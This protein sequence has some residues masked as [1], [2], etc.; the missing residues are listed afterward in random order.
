M[1]KKEKLSLDEFDLDLGMIEPDSILSDIDAQ[2]N[3]DARDK[4]SRNPVLDVFKG[5][6]SGIKDTV[7]TPSFINQ[8]IKQSLPKTYGEITSGVGEIATGISSLYD[9]A[10]KELKP[11]VSRIAKKVDRLVPEENKRLK[12]V[13]SKISGFFGDESTGINNADNQKE[14]AIANS[15][16]AVFQT[17][18]E[19]DQQSEARDNVR[20]QIRE[21]VDKKRFDSNFGLLTSINESVVRLS[22]Y[23]DRINQAFQKKTL[24]LQY[25]QFYAQSELLDTSKRFFEIFKNQNDSVVKNTAL[26]EFVKITNSEKF[27]EIAKNK[28]L[29]GVQSSIFGSES[30][31]GRAMGQMKKDAKEYVSGLKSQLEMSM[32]ALD[33]IEMLREQ[34]EQMAGLGIEMDSPAKMAGGAAGAE[35]AKYTRNKFTDIVKPIIEEDPTI[36]EAL[37]KGANFMSNMSGGVKD[38]QNSDSFKKKMESDG[39][40]GKLARG[41]NGLMSYF[42]DKKF[43][44]ETSSLGNIQSMDTPTNFNNKTQR[45]IVEVIP[46]YLA[47][48]FRE[49]TVLRT[50]DDKTL[51]SYFDYNK[52][53]FIDKNKMAKRI[54]STLS[55]K[56]KASGHDSSLDRVINELHKDDA[57]VSDFDKGNLKNFYSR[58]A[59]IPNLAYSPENIQNTDAYKELD[60]RTR[61]RVD[62]GLSQKI[63][64]STTPEAGQHQF[65]KR[66]GDVKKSLPD[67]RAEIE[68]LVK[69]GYGEFLVEKGLVTE[70]ED[71]SYT[72]DE[73]KYF[74]F[75]RKESI[76]T[77]DKNA[78]KNI[79]SS[80]PKDILNSISGHV[81]SDINSKQSISRF[82]PKGALGA[83]KKTRIYNWLYK[84]GEGDDQPHTGPMAQDV[85][86]TM[87]ENAAP[88]GTSLD[89]TTMN[90]VNMAA[91][92]AL[93]EKVT[94][95]ISGQETTKILGAIKKDTSLIA[96]SF[97]KGRGRSGNNRGSGSNFSGGDGYS[98]IAGNLVKSIT[99]LVGRVGSD[100]FE[101]GSKAISF[102]K[103]K[104]AKPVMDFISK[105][106]TNNKDGLKDTFKTLFTKAG[107]LAGSV[108]DFGQDVITNKLPAGFK[109][110]SDLAS[111]AKERLLRFV[112]YTK[113]VYIQGKDSPALRANLLK[114]GHY[115]DQKSGE[116]I[117]SFKD[118]KG[119][120][121]NKLGEVIL[122]EEDFA[123][124]LVDQE[125]KKID[126]P[127]MKLIK[128]VIGIGIKGLRRTKNLIGSIFKGS[129]EK[130]DQFTDWI[131]QSFGK[132]GKMD[133]GLGSER[134]YTVLT[135]IR[136]TLQG[137]NQKGPRPRNGRKNTRP[138]QAKAEANT[139][140]QYGNGKNIIDTLKDK[141]SELLNSDKVNEYKDKGLGLFNKVQETFS[142]ENRDGLIDKF[143]Q[144]SLKEKGDGLIDT[145]KSRFS[146][147]GREGLLTKVGDKLSSIKNYD[148]K[149]KTDVLK[150][151]LSDK[152]KEKKAIADEKIAQYREKFDEKKALAADKPTEYR[153]KIGEKKD[154]LKSKLPSIK[155]VKKKFSKREEENEG[156]LNWRGKAIYNDRDGSGKRDGSWEDRMKKQEADKKAKKKDAAKADLDPRYKS[157]ENIIDTIFKQAGS[158]FSLLSGGV[159]GMLGQAGSLFSAVGGMLGIGGKGGVIGGLAKGLGGLIKAPFKMIGGAIGAAKAIGTPIASAI[160]ATKGLPMMGKLASLAGTVRNVALTGSILTGGALGSVMG[161]VGA[162]ISALGAVLSS[163][164]V[165]G[166][167]ALAA[168]GYGAYKAYKRI[169]RDS[170]DTFSDIRIKQYGLGA[171]ENQ[172]RYNH[173]ALQL[174]AYLMD[175]R[176]AYNN[177]RPFIIEK[178]IDKQELLSIFDIDKEDDEQIGKFNTWFQR[179]FKPFFLTHLTAL[180]S[181]N[182]KAKLD[183]IVNFKVEQKLKFLSLISFESG[184]YEESASPFK[185]L[186]YLNVDKS[187]PLNSIK[188]AIDKLNEQLS[189]DKDKSSK[190]T[191]DK[192][193]AGPAPE[194]PK[195][196]KPVKPPAPFK[197]NAALIAGNTGED[198]SKPPGQQTPAESGAISKANV[199]LADGPLKDGKAGMQYIKL[200]N[201][202]KLDNLNPELLKNFFAM[203]Q[204]YG[205][206]TAKSILVKSGGRSRAQ[207]EALYRKDPKKAAPPGRSLH[208][209]GLALDADEIAMNE[210]DKLGLMRKYGFTRPVGGEPW[211]VEPAG[212]QSDLNGAK[213]DANNAT[214]KIA[215]SLF[216]GGGGVGSIPGSPLGKRNTSMALQLLDDSA[217]KK[218]TIAANDEKASSGPKTLADKTSLPEAK[219]VAQPNQKA[220]NEAPAASGNIAN[221]G[222]VTQQYA[223]Q[224]VVSDSMIPKEGEPKPES[225]STQETA[226]NGDVKGIIKQVAQKTDTDPNL[227]L[228]FAAMESSLN[229]N[230][231]AG[232]GGTAKGLYGFTNRTWNEKVSQFGGKYGISKDTS[233][234]DPKA[235]SYMVAEYIKQNKNALQSVKSNISPADIYL[236]HFLGTSGAKKFLT[237][238]QNAPG[239]SV[240]PDAAAA[241]K[242]YFYDNGQPL[243]VSQVYNK[244]ASKINKV[245]KQFGINL[246]E[247]S[248]SA[249]KT[250]QPAAKIDNVVPI[251]KAK[252]P[253]PQGSIPSDVQ[254]QTSPENQPTT[255]KPR[256]SIFSA[257]Y[258]SVLNTSGK[259]LNNKGTE[260]NQEAMSRVN[261]TLDKSLD[262]QKQTLDVLK[263]LLSKFNMKSDKPEASSQPEAS[264]LDSMSQR[265]NTQPGVDL[266]RKMM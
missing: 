264:R 45:S 74:K 202:V 265:L 8:T 143:K 211:H 145:I 108:L 32:F 168:V 169:T 234:T 205:E 203:A 117:K 119:T 149:A 148:Y 151:Q 2:M 177:G 15:I 122:T 147:E 224:N 215:A 214:Q 129:K 243:T 191:V 201:G 161:M 56:A 103:N 213:N 170:T 128:G 156:K 255:Q 253:T 179:R 263:Q 13:T 260:L 18:Q 66:M 190:I 134:I 17:Q 236:A 110:I 239:A 204:E 16:A 34:Q 61:S 3:P 91:I 166:V 76:V 219:Q 73:E 133:F 90:G 19:N 187:I 6:V 114:A 48:I 99:S 258:Q 227:M 220:A 254:A 182:P 75:T 218:T 113:D 57:D 232:G 150:G 59:T 100:I 185:D 30:T 192:P 121:V 105:S 216:K 118:I 52:G 212:I 82:S 146:K 252:A 43:D 248:M 244:I 116:V 235:S 38:I 101:G 238:D 184:P 25:R 31:I 186:E 256:P 140:A 189:K 194:V 126:L 131:K 132:L 221:A 11:Q 62:F 21:Q 39:I 54:D 130:G 102:G 85:K 167:A 68:D 237:S 70:N 47:R 208:E 96:G 97:K 233:A 35:I 160:G 89:L 163:P 162:G 112:D 120:V 4:K 104:I 42:S 67:V 209:F 142:K 197:Q 223:Q 152:Y 41:A 127:G 257:D 157:K 249:P 27:Q 261:T 49:I 50:G 23:N 22:T 80:S 94:K 64:N 7:A 266:K 63:S 44:G 225:G 196:D 24:E 10:V 259:D 222:K 79:R 181:L 9:D 81:K 228:A 171:S 198:G 37:A 83:I 125:G 173:Y 180:Y 51:L 217:S 87:G 230:A 26:P 165:L 20:G 175:N 139:E 188:V 153:D 65:T 69:A 107:N 78:K 93:D 136:D 176:I 135:E 123:A 144:S 251:Q 33:S 155:D 1:A 172:K 207:Q 141:G 109:Q 174:E 28:F 58:L 12:K 226:A 158:L 231:K 262:V 95:S 72:I 206:K 60:N 46:G 29:S 84:Q 98:D 250:A 124:G 53:S 245:S 71:G 210:L 92:Q 200:A 36:T 183:E 55:N 246:P 111:G 77:S 242:N 138:Q 178:K 240:M 195:N 14:T 193:K 88:D 241:N 199:A 40:V 229:P 247:G 115:F 5:T 106:Y 137:K 86:Q 164:V 159:T 154:E